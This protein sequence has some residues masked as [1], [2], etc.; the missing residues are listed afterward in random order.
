MLHRKSSYFDAFS[1]IA[2]ACPDS[3]CQEWEVQVDEQTAGR[4]LSLEGALG[5][6]LRQ[7]LRRENG[8][9]LMTIQDRRCPMWRDDGLCRIQA[10]LGE[11]ALCHTCREFPRLTHDYGD[12]QEHTLELSC[13]EAARLIL[14]EPP[15]PM[16]E[17]TVPGG[18]EGDYI[19][20]DMELLL[21]TR[22]TLLSMLTDEARPIGQTLALGLLWGCQTQSLLDGGDVPAFAPETALESA[23]T[24]AKPWVP[25]EFLNFFREL[26]ILT[27][28]W[29][30]RLDTPQ[31]GPWQREHLALARYFVERYW[32]QAVSDFDVYSRA[33]LMITAC[34]LTRLLGGD[35][36]TTAQLFSKEI[37]NSA[38][39]LDA[40][41][42]AAYT[43]RAFT[44]D[45]LL[46]ALLN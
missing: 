12:F 24:L 15:A 34:L 11:E 8:E 29:Q 26:E 4:Y 39:N 19:P 43:H 35:L 9:Y 27:P 3:C 31:P 2:S 13:P 25:E 18:G 5:D 32:L 16:V 33:K 10:E 38:E 22:Q 14:T 23:R 36:V 1:C 30:Q 37:E 6:R 45:K 28:R 17:E 7:V 42:D 44:D 21:S 46:W 20:G 40:L 41:L